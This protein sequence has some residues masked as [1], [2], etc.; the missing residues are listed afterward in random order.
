MSLRRRPG[1]ISTN[2]IYCGPM[3]PMKAEKRRRLEANG[4]KI[5]TADE[6]LCLT[7]E[8][9]AALDDA[10]VASEEDLKASQLID[11]DEVLKTL[12]NPARE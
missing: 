3:T 4:W 7:P 5:G 6:F 9:E 2:S 8:E 10:L 12:R 1:S 11:A